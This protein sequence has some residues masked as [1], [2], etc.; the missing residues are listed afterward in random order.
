M[1]GSYIYD[2]VSPG[3]IRLFYQ[4]TSLGLLYFLIKYRAYG[5]AFLVIIC[6]FNG[7]F[8]YFGATL[9]NIFKIFT[10]LLLSFLLLFTKSKNKVKLSYWIGITFFLFTFFFFL[11]AYLTNTKLIMTL[12]QYSKYLFGLLT[13]LL[14]NKIKNSD[15]RF[16]QLKYLLFSLLL[17]QIIFSIIKVMIMGVQE[18]IVGTIAY[19][20]GGEATTL[21][22]LGF[23][24]LW[25]YRKK[26]LKRLDWLIVIFFF[27]IGY[28]S[29]KRAMWF[30]YPSVIIY[31][32]FYISR[33][34]NWKSITVV[35]PLILLLF[36]F[37][38]RSNPTLNRE[39]ST[40]GSFDLSF[41]TNYTVDY[42]FGTDLEKQKGEGRGGAT[43]LLFSKISGPLTSQDLL[44]SGLAEIYSK[45]YENFDENKYGVNS[46]GSVTGFF[47]NYIS[48]GL[49]GAFITI[50]YML[51]IV[52]VI[53][54]KR[55]RWLILFLVFWDYFFYSGMIFRSYSLSILLM[56]I[57][58]MA[59]LQ[60]ESLENKRI[61]ALNILPSRTNIP[62]R[63]TSIQK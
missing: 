5:F 25:E 60:F 42:S 7:I 58:V 62:E 36:Y 31:Y 55:L 14:L 51:S 16:D 47:Q 6:F 50:L 29:M 49:I 46:K 3:L 27:F 48:F 15:Y 34:S 1:E 20:G 37:G 41:V 8:G 23:I 54:E 26:N 56:M 35:V 52:F 21:P 30:V 43:L 18:S 10:V 12:S 38:V 4:I 57:I 24:F 39:G 61:S 9:E 40:W 13:F 17:S 32:I 19:I 44:G 33:N 45:D 28:A 22:I 53:K 11:S 2:I 59:N 63:F